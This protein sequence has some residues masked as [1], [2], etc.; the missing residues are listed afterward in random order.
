MND[1]VAYKL[2]NDALGAWLQFSHDELSQ[3]IGDAATSE[4]VALPGGRAELVTEVTW[5]DE[6]GGD[7]RVSA[8]LL[9]PSCWSSQRWEQAAVV[10]R[11]DSGGAR[12]R[13]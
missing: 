7:L 4:S 6:P 2:I 13:G 11:P 10:P 3:M 12:R 8:R 9:G 5:A 1:A